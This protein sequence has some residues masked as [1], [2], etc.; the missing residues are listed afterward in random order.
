MPPRKIISGKPKNFRKTFSRMLKDFKSHAVLMVFIIILAI[1][2]AILSIITPSL[3]RD[4]LNSAEQELIFID[5]ITNTINIH[6]MK[7]ISAFLRTLPLTALLLLGGGDVLG[8]GQYN[9]R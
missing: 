7:S 6:S 3:L 5:Y 1:G 2:S 8:S 4:L 9:H